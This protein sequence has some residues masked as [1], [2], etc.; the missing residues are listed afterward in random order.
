MITLQMIYYPNVNKK[1]M[2]YWSIR[3]SLDSSVTGVNNAEAQVKTLHEKDKYSFINE[4]EEYYFVEF[5]RSIW[6]NNKG[7]YINN[8][9][10]V[11]NSKISIITYFLTGK[12]VKVVD[13]YKHMTYSSFNI[14]DYVISDKLLGIIGS[15][16]MPQL[17]IIPAR[18]IGFSVQC[19]LIGFPIIPYSDINFEKSIF[20]NAITKLNVAFHNHD[21][22]KNRE[23]LCIV[24]QKIV[25]YKKYDYDI[26]RTPLGLFFSESLI[27]ELQKN[28]VT[29][30]EIENV[31]LE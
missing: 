22:Y 7:N 11:D 10:K 18:I 6:K 25:L 30:L 9:V 19:Y 26:L 12:K 16:N 15:F 13:M 5:C 24:P 8:F 2:K 27:S 20:I 31:S 14:F 3:H 1:I 23:T 4:K 17:N 29:G 28:N 21:E